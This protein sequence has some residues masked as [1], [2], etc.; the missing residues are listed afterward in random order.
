MAVILELGCTGLAHAL[1]TG[2]IPQP[3]PGILL[4]CAAFLSREQ[5]GY[6]DGWLMLAL[7]MWL[8]LPELLWILCMGMGLGALYGCCFR[9]KELPLVP[10]LTVVYVI[11]EWL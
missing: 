2:H 4:F 6:G 10:F 11:G 1:R 7:G 3:G 8:D 5:I 9:Q